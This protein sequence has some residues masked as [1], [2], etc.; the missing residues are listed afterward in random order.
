MENPLNQINCPECGFSLPTN[1][2]KCF[3]CGASL[4]E[5]E[6][7]SWKESL[8][9]S[10][11]ATI[12]LSI[13]FIGAIVLVFGDFQFSRFILRHFNIL[14]HEFGHAIF[15]W[16]SGFFSVP[17][18]DFSHG[19]GVT[20]HMGD[21]PNKGILVAV[22]VIFVWLLYAFKRYKLIF[23]SIAGI[24]TLLAL[25]FLF[26]WGPLVMMYGGHGTVVI[27]GGLFLFR[28]LSNVAVHHFAERIL[29]FFLAAFVILDEL[30]FTQM[31]K[32]DAGFRSQYLDGKG[33]IMN[34]FHK[35]SEHLNI[36]LNTAVNFHAFFCFLVPVLAYAIYVIAMKN[37]SRET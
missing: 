31:L 2:P 20:V 36:S 3:N 11:E 24:F 5:A 33:G 21:K 22:A 1:A 7:N 34:D 15:G 13:G 12:A 17:A 4:Y 16:L 37:Y 29:Y 8:S 32:K 30:Q 35:I 23:A 10:K 27:M 19:G 26:G 25:S 14:V 18:F 28:G 9:I 6:E